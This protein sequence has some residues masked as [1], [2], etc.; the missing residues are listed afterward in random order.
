MIKAVPSVMR[1]KDCR[2]CGARDLRMVLQLAPTPPADAYVPAARLRQDQGL[3]PLDLF[4]CL[5]CGHLQLLDVIDPEVL[6]RDYLYTTSSSLGL[7][8]HFRR[9]AD[10]ILERFRPPQGSLAV[11]IGSNEGVLLR[12]FQKHG[13][14]V[15]GVDPARDVALSATRAGIE[16]IPSFFGSALAKRI[17]KDYAAAAV[18]TAN[19]VF[20]HADNLGDM[21]EGVRELLASDGVFVFEVSYI[22]DLVR[23]MVFDFIYHEHLCYH[24]VKPMQSFLRRH[25]MEL[26]DVKRDPMKGGS[27]RGVAQLL[28]GPR[29]A[30]PSVPEFIRMEESLRMEDP[31]IFSDF[32]DK[33]KAEKEKLKGLLRGIR[34]G[35]KTIAGYGASATTTTLLYHF[36]LGEDLSFIVD[37][38]PQ[39]QNLYSPGYHIPIL[40]PKALY[41][42]KPHYVLVLAWRYAEAIL[43]QHSAF[44]KQGGR[45][46]VPL[47]KVEVV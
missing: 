19:N 24:S 14:R 12:F 15:L 5:K 1:R 37:D 8:E 26:I 18:V 7:V 31:G 20:A 27:Y 41:E 29:T 3:F 35:G 40:S 11:D 25:G 46:I 28:N 4:L 43:K 22:V 30:A 13:M 9:Y 2:L 6:Y 32:S 39:R 17:R 38:N 45:F 34:A 23:N 10:D 16:T 36:G 21:A 47:P 44:S 33:I 42:R